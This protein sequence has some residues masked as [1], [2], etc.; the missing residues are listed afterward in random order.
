M[1]PEKIGSNFN[2]STVLR[3][4]GSMVKLEKQFREIKSLK[5]LRTLQLDLSIHITGFGGGIGSAHD[6]PG[7]WQFVNTCEA[8][9]T[10]KDLIDALYIKAQEL[11]QFYPL[12][13]VKKL[14]YGGSVD[15]G[16]PASFTT[17]RMPGWPHP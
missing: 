4:Y 5:D 8:L 2:G 10:C 17:T 12:E 15:N 14:I 3:L 16:L 13:R 1:E 6:Q 7:L 11:D 9:G